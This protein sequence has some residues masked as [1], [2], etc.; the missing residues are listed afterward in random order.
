M[1]L[2]HLVSEPHKPTSTHSKLMLSSI[3]GV[4]ELFYDIFVT[5][6]TTYTQYFKNCY[7]V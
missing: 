5:T 6:V 7:R 1:S 3:Y 2:T 4:H